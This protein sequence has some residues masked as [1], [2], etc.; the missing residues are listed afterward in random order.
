[1]DDDGFVTAADA[2]LALRRA[3]ELETYP[4]GSRAYVACNVNRDDAVTAA[5]ARSILRAAVALEDP[6]LW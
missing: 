1:M 3:V 4:K 5:D 6:A 2:R